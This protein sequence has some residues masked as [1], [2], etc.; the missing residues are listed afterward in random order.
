M[1]INDR[2]VLCKAPCPDCGG[3]V[4]EEYFFGDCRGNPP[5]TTIWCKKCKREFSKKEWEKIEK[6][7]KEGKVKKKP[8]M[9]PKAKKPECRI[10][11]RIRK[12]I[13]GK[14]IEIDPEHQPISWKD[15]EEIVKK[16]FAGEPIGDLLVLVLGPCLL[17]VGTDDKQ[18]E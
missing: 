3:K 12:Y 1:G 9:K 7:A 8:S 13:Y 16:E 11:Y 6:K 17:T 2:T 5:V 18:T 14:E 4:C 15:L 10:P